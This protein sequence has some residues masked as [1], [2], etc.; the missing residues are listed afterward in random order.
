MHP[1][2]NSQLANQHQTALQHEAEMVRL[3]SQVNEPKRAGRP[4][5]T[6][7]TRRPVTFFPL[8][9]NMTKLSSR[10]AVVIPES[11]VEEVPFAEIRSALQATFSMMHEVGLISDYDDT[12][13]AQFN[14]TFERELV[15]QVQCHSV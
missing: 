4:H 5:R 12:F 14:E 2:M 11:L 3:A 8:R 7:R 1:L 15:H 6:H 10:Q 13:M 9:S